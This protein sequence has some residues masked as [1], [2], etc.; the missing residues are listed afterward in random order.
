MEINSWCFDDRFSA[1]ECHLSGSSVVF[2]FLVL[3]D[4]LEWWPLTLTCL[5]W[6]HWFVDVFSKI[7]NFF[8]S[9]KRRL[10]AKYSDYTANNHELQCRQKYNT[11]IESFRLQTAVLCGSESAWGN[12]VWNRHK[13]I[14]L[15]VRTR[16]F[17]PTSASESTV[18]LGLSAHCSGSLFFVYKMNLE[19]LRFLPTF[20]IL[21]CEVCCAETSVWTPGKMLC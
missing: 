9:S 19:S 1:E 5:D 20:D 21:F 12:R 16:E 10:N 18:T 3:R 2:A 8:L 14:G 4:C 11:R 15:R 13:N 6:G 7:C 17:A